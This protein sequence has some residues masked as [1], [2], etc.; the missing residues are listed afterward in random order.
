VSAC[1]LSG[2][3]TVR[4]WDRNEVRVRVSD[5]VDID[6]ARVDQTKSQSATELKLISKGR[7]EMRGSSCLTSA[8]IEMDVPRAGGINIQTTNGDISVTGIGQLRAVTISGSITVANIQG[9]INASTIGGELSV[10]DSS[11]SFKLSST[12][13]SIDARDLKPLSAGDAVSASTVSGE[14]KLTHVQHERVSVNSVSGEATYVGALPRN[15]NYSV[16]SLS[17][18]V[19]LI[20]PAASSFR[21]TAMVGESV[22]ITSDFNLKYSENQNPSGAGNH[23]APRHLSATVGSGDASVHVQLLNGG[24]RISKQ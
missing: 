24:L 13:G 2:N 20:I 11:G 9:E 16:H 7:H 8:D 18:E 21:L 14:V 15:G 4:G 5:G 12:G 6:L 10:R 19:R 22:K 17:G 3:F 1:T 23:G